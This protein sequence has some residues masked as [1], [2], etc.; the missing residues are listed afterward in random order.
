MSEV[1]HVTRLSYQGK[2]ILLVGTAHVSKRSVQEVQRVIRE[3]RPDTVCVELDE[4]RYQTL[5]DQTRW[6]KLDIFQIIRQKRVLFLL[7]SLALSSYQRRLGERLGVSPGAEL[8]AAVDAA[9]EVGAQV[10]LVDRDVQATLKRTWAN[11]GF[12]DRTQLVSGLVAA[13]FSV[14]EIDESKIEELKHKDTIGEMLHQ[15][16]QEFPRIKTPL[17]DESDLYLISNIREAPG[18]KIVGVV[19]AAHVSGMKARLQEAVDRAEL[20]RIPPPTWLAR[21]LNWIFPLL[22]LAAFGYGYYEHQGHGLMQLVTAWVL[23]TAVF[24]GLF[25]A[26]ALAHPLSILTAF[27]V[28]PLTTINPLIA[29]GMVSGLVEA[30]VRRPTVEDCENVQS[31][32]SSVR[33]VYQNRVTRVML[34]FMLSNLG[35]ALGAW[36]GLGWV[37]SLL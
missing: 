9:K 32:I 11:L 2:E 24:A 21:S 10:L 27:L 6:R 34:V 12:W 23:P 33:G 4:G 1:G 15:V 20:E 22:V 36:I 7:S 29:S 3:E 30:Y 35:S 8:L 26:F 17:I 14:E 19:G 37:L 5:I 25:T 31:S 28:S 13:P 16:A 18:P